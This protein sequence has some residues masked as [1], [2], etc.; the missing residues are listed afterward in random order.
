M[1]W[2][3]QKYYRNEGSSVAG[4]W[5][6]STDDRHNKRLYTKFQLYTYAFS[7]YKV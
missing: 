2:I 5:K 3:G 1:K 7:E 6:Q 4:L